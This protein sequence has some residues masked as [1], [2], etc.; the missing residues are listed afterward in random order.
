MSISLPTSSTVSIYSYMDYSSL[1]I[2]LCMYIYIYVARLCMPFFNRKDCNFDE[3]I[4]I[5]ELYRKLLLIHGQHLS[6]LYLFNY[7]SIYPCVHIDRDRI[8]LIIPPRGFCARI[9]QSLLLPPPLALPTRLQ[10]YCTTIGQYTPSP[11]A[12]FCT[13]YTI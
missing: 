7:L 2:N 12:R 4:S 13:P 6:L 5:D 1:Y 11:V 3:Y 8:N 9:H 10:Y